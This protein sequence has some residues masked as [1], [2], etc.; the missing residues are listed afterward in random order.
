MLELKAET[1]EI[2]GKKVKKLRKT[3]YIPAV[4][5]GHG[6]KSLS[7]MVDAKEFNRAFKEAGETSLLHLVLGGKK[8]NVLIH[9]LAT[10]PLSGE[11]LHVDFFEVK[12][13]EKIKTKVPLVFVGESSAVKGE[14]GVLVKAMQEVELE[15]LPQDLPKEIEV[16]ISGLETFEDKIYIKD[17]K[18]SGS[19][20]ILAD[21]EEMVA[22]VA[23]PR[24]EKELAEL[25]QKPVG[26]VGEVPV[27]GEEEK[28]AATAVPAAEEQPTKEKQPAK[29][30]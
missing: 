6:V 14:G 25:E 12:M 4:L 8:H 24:S 21:S 30:G 26:E 3:G 10:G 19:V 13:D 1:R 28:A 22:A 29:E 2:T 17:L 7:L 15:A 16:E 9:D 18:V 27:V 23:P 5:Y 11:I 20:K